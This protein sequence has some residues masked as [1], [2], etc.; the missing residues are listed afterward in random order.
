MLYL[1][2]ILSIGLHACMC[3]ICLEYLCVISF[4]ELS[5]LT[6]LGITLEFVYVILSLLSPGVN[7]GNWLAF[8]C[9]VVSLVD[10]SRR[11]FDDG[12]GMHRYSL[13]T[14]LDCCSAC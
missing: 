13:C 10:P 4:H 12:V 7:L 1:F 3:Q 6:R 5:F 9:R 11:M 2:L 8:F 14:V